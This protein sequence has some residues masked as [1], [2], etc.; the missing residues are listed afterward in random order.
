MEWCNERDGIRD[1][2]PNFANYFQDTTINWY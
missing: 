1:V 2:Y